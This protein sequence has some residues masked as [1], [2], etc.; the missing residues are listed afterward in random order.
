VA[1]HLDVDRVDASTELWRPDTNLPPG[2][3][4]LVAVDDGDGVRALTV[5]RW[6]LVP[7]WAD[8][9]AIGYR[10]IN[11]RS[12]TAATKPS[13]RRSVRTRRALVSADAFYEWFRPAS[14]QKQPYLIHRADGEPLAF[15]ALWERWEAP[16][17][18]PLRTVAVLTTAANDDVSPLHDR[19]PVVV[20]R[21][22]WD[23]WLRPEPL[24]TGRFENLCAPA[25]RGVVVHR[26]VSTRVN[27]ARH[28]GSDLLDA[29][30]PADGA[31]PGTD[32]TEP[33]A[34]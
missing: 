16:D 34:R 11:A 8:D 33:L 28:K 20:E 3:P 6:G 7:S 31:P 25:P 10:M 2:G 5:M 4:L 15:G 32:G 22:D 23:E 19:M 18:E 27:D 24:E 29:V 13:F 21:G 30:T 1:L 14:G 9:P 12:E 26:A 17:G